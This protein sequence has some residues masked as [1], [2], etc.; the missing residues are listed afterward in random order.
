MRLGGVS[1]QRARDDGAADVHEGQRLDEPDG[2]TA[3]AAFGE[4]RAVVA[5]P[6]G[7]AQ[8][9]GREPIEHALA[10]VV[11]GVPVLRAGVAEPHHDVGHA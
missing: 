10:H 11:T 1:P 2:V 4:L 5:V 3:P 7:A 9:A 6:A 8:V